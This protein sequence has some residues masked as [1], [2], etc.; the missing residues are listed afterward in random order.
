MKT[1]SQNT[2][3]NSVK[4]EGAGKKLAL[5]DRGSHLAQMARPPV[6]INVVVDGISKKQ[7]RIM[8]ARLKRELEEWSNKYGFS[9][10]TMANKRGILLNHWAMPENVFV[11]NHDFPILH[12]H[13]VLQPI[14]VYQLL[15]DLDEELRQDCSLLHQPKDYIYLMEATVAFTKI[16]GRIEMLIAGSQKTPA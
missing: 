1:R 8:R 14:S 2:T 16:E 11:D 7:E 15:N 4:A 3:E 5:S 10:L 12:F 13:P 6:S 9:L